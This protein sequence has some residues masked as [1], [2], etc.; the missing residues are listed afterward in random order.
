MPEIKKR[1]MVREPI[2]VV[3]QTAAA[4]RRMKEALVKAKER[5]GKTRQQKRKA[6]RNTHQIRSLVPLRLLSIPVCIWRGRPH[7]AERKQLRQELIEWK[8]PKLCSLVSSRGIR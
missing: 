8:I 5:P 4:S 2:K 7:E 3:D 1:D 6:R